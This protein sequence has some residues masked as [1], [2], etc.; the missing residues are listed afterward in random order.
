MKILRPKNPSPIDFTGRQSFYHEAENRWI[1]LA[2]SELFFFFRSFR[3]DDEV[4]I[5]QNCKSFTLMNLILQMPGDSSWITTYLSVASRGDIFPDLPADIMQ[6]RQ[7]TT[8]WFRE[9]RD[10]PVCSE[11]NLLHLQDPQ[12]GG[13]HYPLRISFFGNRISVSST[14]L[15]LTSAQEWEAYLY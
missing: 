8:M 11:A 4:Q 3:D 5:V 10:V 1:L 12:S 7:H 6:I 2:T 14:V 15:Y 13:S 9:L